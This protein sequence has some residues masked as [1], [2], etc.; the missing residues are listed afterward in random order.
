MTIAPNNEKI[1]ILI[2]SACDI[3]HELIEKYHMKVIR[4]HVLYPEKDYID[5]LDI[6]ARMVYDRFPEEIPSTST[7]GP[8]D[9]RDMVDEIK[10][11]GY[12]HILAFSISSGL[13]G[14]YNTVCSVLNEETDIPCFVLDTKNISSGAGVFALWAGSQ[15]EEGRSYEELTELLPKKVRDSKV[16]YYMD[17]LTYLQKGGR[18]GLVTSILGNML[19]LKPIISCNEEGVYYTI[20]KIRGSKQGL[21]KL[22]TEVKTFAGDSHC[23]I[24]LLNGDGREAAEQMRPL[25]LE[26]ISNGTIIMEKQITASMAVHTGPGLVGIGIFKL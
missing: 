12:T 18:I 1:A 9:V 2:D 17:T 13:S 6:E 7:P 19:N 25:L 15:I 14:T 5:D 21:S 4:L 16:L 26:G 24:I 8:Q 10:A 23:W 22:F 11:E 20:A 3:T